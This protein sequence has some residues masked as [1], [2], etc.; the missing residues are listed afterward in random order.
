VEGELTPEPR[1]TL[2]FGYDPIFIA[3]GHRS[4]FGEMDPAEK[5]AISHRAKAFAAFAAAEL[6]A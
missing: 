3:D 2:G 5:D 1:G 6:D 4:T